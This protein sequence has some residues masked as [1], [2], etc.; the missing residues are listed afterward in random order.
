MRISLKSVTKAFGPMHAL[1]DFS[2]N[3]DPGQVVAVLGLNGAGKTGPCWRSSSIG[4]VIP[5]AGEIRCDGERFDRDRV[6]LRKRMFFLPDFFAPALPQMTV[7]HHIDSV[8]RVYE[9]ERP[10]A[11]ERAIQLLD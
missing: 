5:D 1:A 11:D 7:L 10:A 6:D 9:A 3:I 4:I 8:L 2:M